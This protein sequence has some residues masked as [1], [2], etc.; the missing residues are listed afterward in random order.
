[1]IRDGG[2][3]GGG[4]GV[5]TPNYILSWETGKVQHRE[6]LTADELKWSIILPRTLFIVVIVIWTY[7]IVNKKRPIL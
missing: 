4:G 1:M 6:V 5:S 3:G 7:L 2:G